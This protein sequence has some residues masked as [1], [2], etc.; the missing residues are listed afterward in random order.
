MQFR[1][2]VAHNF[3][4]DNSWPQL[5]HDLKSA[6]QSSDIFNGGANHPW[7]TL[8]ALS[9]LQNVV[10]PFQVSPPLELLILVWTFVLL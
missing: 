8:S 6:I 2:V 1:I 4:K 3:V 5:V 7:K 9:I 10:R